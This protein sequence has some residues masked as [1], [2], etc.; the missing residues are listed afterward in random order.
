[1]INDEKKFLAIIAADK[2]GVMT[3]RVPDGF[4]EIGNK[5]FKIYSKGFV[6]IIAEMLNISGNVK[7]KLVGYYDID[8]DAVVFDLD[9]YKFGCHTMLSEIDV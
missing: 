2:E 6:R 5:A 4:I 9:K 8:M 7:I 1:M 3:F